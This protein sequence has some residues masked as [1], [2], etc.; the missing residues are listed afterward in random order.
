VVITSIAVL[1]VSVVFTV[2][3]SAVITSRTVRLG[4]GAI[5]TSKAICKGKNS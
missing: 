3:I 5:Q 4:A 1:T 2:T